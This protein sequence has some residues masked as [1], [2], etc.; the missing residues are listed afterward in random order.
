V[1]PQYHIV[2]DDKFETVFH[3][4]KTLEE[5]DKICAEL[6]V[7]S[8]EWFVEEEYE[9][10]GLLIYKPPPSMKCGFWSRTAVIDASN[11]RSSEIVRLG[12][13]LWKQRKLRGSLRGLVLLCRTWLNQM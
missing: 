11:W 4:G 9:E 10:D 1:S 6:F 13:M 2:F 12:S 5:L 7:N 8:R 3:D